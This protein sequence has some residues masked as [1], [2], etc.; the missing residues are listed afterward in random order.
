VNLGT[1]SFCGYDNNGDLL[2]TGYA[3][4]ASSPFGVVEL[5]KGAGRF[6][7]I[8]FGVYGP[9]SYEPRP[10]QWDGRY[11]AVGSTDSIAQYTIRGFAAVKEGTTTFRDL[12]TLGNAWIQDSKVIVVNIFGSGGFPP[13]QIDKYPAGGK[14]VKTINGDFSS[15]PF[16]VTVSQAPR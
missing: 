7:E 9:S 16:G 15:D 5:Q 13:V 14:P 11:V 12:H 4:G 1:S 10:I 6:R 8:A 3:Y 2:V